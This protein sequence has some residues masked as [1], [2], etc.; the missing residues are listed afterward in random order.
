MGARSHSIEHGVLIAIKVFEQV[1][2]EQKNQLLSEG[3]SSLQVVQILR[4]RIG[5]VPNVVATIPTFNLEST[6]TIET[7]LQEVK[8]LKSQGFN[9]E[10]AILEIA[11]RIA[12]N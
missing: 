1:A 9:T 8:A 12:V 2:R 4:S 11:R 5:P 10:G 7:L 6:I 3:Y